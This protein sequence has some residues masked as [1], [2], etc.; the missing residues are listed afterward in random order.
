MLILRTI[1]A[2]AVIVS[3]LGYGGILPLMPLVFSGYRILRFPPEIWRMV[4]AFLI[5]G[6]NLSIIF[7]PYFCKHAITLWT[8]EAPTDK[9]CPVYTYGSQLENGSAKF[10]RPGDFFTYVVFVATVIV[11]SASV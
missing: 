3:A 7:D 9:Y 11:V 1:T 2:A 10:T 8:R 6:P 4:T 5:T